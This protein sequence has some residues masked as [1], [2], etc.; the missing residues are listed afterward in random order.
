VS[1]VCRAEVMSPDI[2]RGPCKGEHP[3]PGIKIKQTPAFWEQMAESEEED[4]AQLLLGDTRYEIRDRSYERAGEQ[5]GTC[6]ALPSR[7]RAKRGQLKRVQRF[8][9]ESQDQN[10]VRTVLRAEFSRQRA[11]GCTA[12]YR[13]TSITRKRPPPPLGPSWG[14]R[15]RPSVGS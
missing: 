15:H 2:Q 5:S 4:Q 7:C 9:P 14:H 11:G 6:R 12:L 13:D 10:L 8:S 1:D 3:N